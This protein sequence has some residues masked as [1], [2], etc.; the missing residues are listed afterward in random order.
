MSSFKIVNL[1]QHQHRNMVY[2]V[3]L[4]K[5]T[6]KAAGEWVSKNGENKAFITL[7]IAYCYSTDLYVG[8]L[9]F[10]NRRRNFYLLLLQPLIQKNCQQINNLDSVYLSISCA[11]ETITNIEQLTMILT[12]PLLYILCI[13]HFQLPLGKYS[14]KNIL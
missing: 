13:E 3:Y 7:F 9:W 11:C 10:D 1:F 4:P 14:P 2:L 5:K 6:I 8:G 12:F